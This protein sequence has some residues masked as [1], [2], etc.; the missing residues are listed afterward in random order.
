MQDKPTKKEAQAP[1]ITRSEYS[2]PRRLQPVNWYTVISAE[3]ERKA[4]HLRA[5]LGQDVGR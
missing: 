5:A 3:V 1:A 2:A 4:E